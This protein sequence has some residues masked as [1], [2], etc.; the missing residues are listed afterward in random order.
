MEQA[1]WNERAK[2]WVLDNTETLGS[3]EGMLRTVLFLMPGRFRDSEVILELLYS[4]V[5]LLSLSHDIIVLEHLQKERANPL[6]LDLPLPPPSSHST[7]KWLSFFRNSELLFEMVSKQVFGNKAKWRTIIAIEVVKTALKLDLLWEMG[8]RMILHQ[9]VPQYRDHPA[10]KKYVDGEGAPRRQTL[11]EMR[12]VSANKWNQFKSTVKR[13]DNSMGQETWILSELLFILRPI[14]YLMLIFR[15]GHKSWKAWIICLVL[16]LLSLRRY[17]QNS[18]R[19]TE[20]QQ[21]EVQRRTPLLLLY[22]L[23]SPMFDF[24]SKQSPL[25]GDKV[26]TALPFLK[27]LL[28]AIYEN[29]AV[30]RQHYFYISGSD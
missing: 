8:G 12:K 4:S 18:H 25:V 16:D 24:I 11:R 28:G 19:L 20:P 26:T 14:I 7:L 2:K 17:M 29:I 6:L 10:F 5:G 30:Y 23:R 1:S 27:G 22:L 15:W 21:E 9:I 3:I 13:G